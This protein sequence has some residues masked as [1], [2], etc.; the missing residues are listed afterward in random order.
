[1]SFKIF[2]VNTD[3]IASGK[4][5]EGTMSPNYQTLLNLKF[6]KGISTYEL[7]R[8]FPEAIGRVSEVALLDVPERVLKEILKEE[9]LYDRLMRLKK[10]FL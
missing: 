9:K 2:F 1:M 7:V 3:E 6:R 4:M 10:K 5:Q 8:Q